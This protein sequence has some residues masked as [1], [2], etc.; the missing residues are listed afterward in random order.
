MFAC[1]TKNL[2]H[3]ARDDRGEKLV[4]INK[5]WNARVGII[6]EALVFHILRFFFGFFP[7]D[8]PRSGLFIE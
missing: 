3:K 1:T 7:M 2:L 6:E 4:N 8:F 5:K